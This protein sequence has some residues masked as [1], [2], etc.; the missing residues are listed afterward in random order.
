MK[1]A[2]SLVLVVLMLTSIL[3]SFN[4][5]E[6]NEK[7]T[8]NDADA[9]ADYEVWLIGANSPRE[10][11]VGIAGDVRNAVDV[12]E[13]VTFDFKMSSCNLSRSM[14]QFLGIATSP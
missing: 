10:S 4:P 7:E 6:M 9:R 8:V 1:R 13:S 2:T 5:I 14:S 12:N 3:A 11:T